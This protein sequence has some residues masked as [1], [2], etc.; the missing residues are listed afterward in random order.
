MKISSPSLAK[1]SAFVTQ[2]FRILVTSLSRSSPSV[3][4]TNGC[5]CS[6][7]VA[8][9]QLIFGWNAANHGYPRTISSPPRSVT[10]KRICSF[11]FP[12]RICKSTKLLI[13]PALLCVPSMFQIVLGFLSESFPIFILFRSFS[14][15]KFSVAPESTSTCLSAIECAVLNRVGIRR[16]LYLHLNTLV[17]PKARTQADGSVPFKNPLR[18]LPSLSAPL[19]LFQER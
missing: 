1:L 17:T 12:H 16:L 2:A 10:K 19:Y 3:L 7:M 11:W 9:F 18:T 15:M 14:L 6:S 4:I 5:M 8:S 13:C